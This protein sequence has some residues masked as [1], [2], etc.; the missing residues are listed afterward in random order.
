MALRKLKACNHCKGVG[1]VDSFDHEE[2]RHIRERAGISLR[3]MA[4]RLKLSAPYLSD[5]ERGN[6]NCTEDIGSA[7][8]KLKP[9][10]K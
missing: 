7:Y 8:E 4:I 2:L 5:I 10:R 3:A 1:L 9:K 6:R